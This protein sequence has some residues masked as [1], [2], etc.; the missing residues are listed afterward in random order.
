MPYAALTAMMIVLNGS[1]LHAASRAAAAFRPLV[2][3][4]LVRRVRAKTAALVGEN[5]NR[6][7]NMGDGAKSNFFAE[8][9][10]RFR[11]SLQRAGSICSA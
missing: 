2:L 1:C 11:N 4:R 10:V 5:L 9:L 6:V 7:T 3:H 8:S